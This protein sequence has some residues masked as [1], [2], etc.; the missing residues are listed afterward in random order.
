MHLWFLHWFSACVFVF[1]F[2][3]CFCFAACL[4]PLC[5]RV[6]RYAWWIWKCKNPYWASGAKNALNQK[7]LVWAPCERVRCAVYFHHRNRI[8]RKGRRPRQHHWLQRVGLLLV[9]TQLLHP[10]RGLRL[11]QAREEQARLKWISKLRDLIA[12]A[13]LPASVDDQG[14]SRVGKGRRA[15]TLRAHVQTCG[16]GL[17]IG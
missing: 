7:C 13:G 11:R 3:I 9:E 8:C 17:Q 1:R 12:A 2:S 14:V 4:F 5:G 6:A 16:V 15:S 10:W